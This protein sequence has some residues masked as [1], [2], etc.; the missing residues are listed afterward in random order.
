MSGRLWVIGDIHGYSL[1]LSRLLERIDP[2]KDDTIVTLGDYIDRGPDSAGVLAAL[3]EL[4]KTCR[5]AALRGNHEDILLEVLRQEER[6]SESSQS[7]ARKGFLHFFRQNKERPRF[8]LEDWL[9]YGGR[10]TL[11]SYDIFERKV[12]LLPKEHLDFIRRTRLY[13]ETERYIFTHA[14]YVP[15]LPLSDQPKDALLF[16]KLQL[17]IPAEH[18]SSR[19]AYVGHSAQH[20]GEILDAGHLVCLDTYLYGG[21]WLTAMEPDTGKILQVDSSGR[22]RS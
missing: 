18:C 22:F 13:F 15:E 21:G 17:G 4:E 1:A 10:Q 8:T 6:P 14:A 11:S 7:S 2:G 16:Y 9:S 19:R 12:S 3:L 20:T 5:L